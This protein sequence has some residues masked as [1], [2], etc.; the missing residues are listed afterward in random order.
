MRKHAGSCLCGEVRFEVTGEFDGFFLCHCSR[1]RK[2]TGSAH[3]ANLFSS[4]AALDWLA[5]EAQVQTYSVEGTRHQRSFCGACGSAVPRKHP[6]A[7]VVVPAGSLDTALGMTPTA[8]ICCASRADWDDKLE[9][10]QKF[11]GLPWE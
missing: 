11:D 8:H 6:L 7:G 4:R 3:A 1:C 10:V 5:G 2:G 9:D